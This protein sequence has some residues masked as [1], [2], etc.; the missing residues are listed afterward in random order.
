[1][2]HRDKVLQAVFTAID[3]FNMLVTHDRQL[4]KSTDTPLLSDPMQLDSMGVVNFIVAAEEEIE[5]AFAVSVSLT[6]VLAQSQYPFQTVGTLT[7]YIT[8]IVDEH[9]NV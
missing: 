9:A 7:D 4:E 8:T 3:N 2:A 6:N 5:K 1:M